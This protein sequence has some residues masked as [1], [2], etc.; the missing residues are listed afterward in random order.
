MSKIVIR[1]VAGATKKTRRLTH[2]CKKKEMTELFDLSDCGNDSCSEND[3]HNM[4]KIMVVFSFEASKGATDEAAEGLK[5][6]NASYG[7]EGMGSGLTLKEKS[8]VHFLN[9]GGGL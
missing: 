9:S 8:H 2:R 5:E 7:K 3:Q 6:L 1:E 4:N